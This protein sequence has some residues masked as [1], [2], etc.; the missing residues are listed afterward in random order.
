MTGARGSLRDWSSS[1]REFEWSRPTAWRERDPSRRIAAAVATDMHR[2]ILFRKAPARKAVTE[3]PAPSETIR[4]LLRAHYLPRHG[5]GGTYKEFRGARETA[6][7]QRSLFPFSDAG[8]FFRVLPVGV[9]SS[10]VGP[11]HPDALEQAIESARQLMTLSSGWDDEESPG[12]T[13]GTLD[14]AAAFL[15]TEAAI[16]RKAG[17][18]MAIPLIQ[19][20]P[21][22]S[23]DLHWQTQS[24]ELLVNIPADPQESV[25]FYGD[26]Y[27]TGVVKGTLPHPIN[28]GLL[29]WLMKLP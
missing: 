9:T 10:K 20:G 7:L 14:R 28:I 22:G 18:A 4:G 6:P 16:L 29:R 15:R 1:R 17:A 21:E 27:G 24:W 13:I 23:I 12:Y 26:D 3:F 5:R 25:G 8:R 2:A 19:P 11:P